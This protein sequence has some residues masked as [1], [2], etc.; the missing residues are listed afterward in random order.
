M[1][2]RT[3]ILWFLFPW[4][5]PVTISI[6]SNLL[7]LSLLYL[8]QFLTWNRFLFPRGESKI[9]VQ[10]S[11][12]LLLGVVFIFNI[13]I[14]GILDWRKQWN[15]SIKTGKK[16]IAIIFLF[17][18]KGFPSNGDIFLRICFN[19]LTVSKLKRCIKKKIIIFFVDIVFVNQYSLQP[20]I[21]GI[22]HGKS[23]VLLT[24][25]RRSIQKEGRLLPI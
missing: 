23:R 25:F 12:V 24:L 21:P 1:R 14:Y 2:V 11:T 15:K 5:L 8:Y 22:N 3:R 19:Q 20:F 13:F 16:L 17:N 4:R 6:F 9:G 18:Q 10:C 7:F